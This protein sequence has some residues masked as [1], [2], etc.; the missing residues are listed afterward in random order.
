MKIAYITPGSGDNFYCQNCFRDDEF[1]TS[2]ILLGHDVHK[3][4]MY[5]PSGFERDGKVSSSPVFYGAINVYLREKI[6]GYTHAPSWMEKALD[7]QP[8]LRY[9]AKKSGSTDASGLE[10]M[11]LSML[12]GEKGRHAAELDNLVRHLQ[13]EIDPAIVHLSNAL[14]LGLAYRLKHDLGAKVVCSLQDENEWIDE[15]DPEQQP[16]VWGLMGEK[17]AYVDAFIAT[18]EYYSQRSQKE[19]SIPAEQ[20]RV[21]NGGVNLDGYQRSSHPLDPPVLG[22]MCRI[23]EYFGFGIVVDAFLTLKQD[24]RFKDLQLY[25]TGGYTGLDKPFVD[26]QIKKIHERGFEQDLKIFPEFHKSSRIEFLRSLTLLS[27]PVPSGEAFGAYQVEALAAGVPVVQPKVGCYPEFVDATQGGIIYEPN[28]PA[29]LAQ[30]VAALLDEPERIKALG[31]QGHKVVMERNTM[32][33]MA[34]TI[35]QIYN[36]ILD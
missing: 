13:E 31:E 17:A 29:T 21:I 32:Q 34:K 25:V 24:D 30:A 4:P 36:D 8:L 1:L 28:T 22:Y 3:V 19:M 5:L 14:L 15:M 20:I 26:A 9:A 27:V 23:S 12:Q 10:G 11:T 16:A 7:S 2:L 18:S 35:V 33:K 6:P